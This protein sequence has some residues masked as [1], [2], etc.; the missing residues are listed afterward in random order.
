MNEKPNKPEP[1]SIKPEDLKRDPRPKWIKPSNSF[2]DLEI[3]IRAA[4]EEKELEK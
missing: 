3:L 1:K 2:A 4:E